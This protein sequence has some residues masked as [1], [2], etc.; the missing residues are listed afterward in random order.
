MTS[1]ISATREDHDA[2]FRLI[3]ASWTSQVTSTLAK[4]SIA[5]QFD[6]GPR[7]AREIADD[8]SSDPDMTY[9]VLRAAAALGFLVYDADTSR[10]SGTTM[11]DVLRGES[12]LSLKHYALTAGSDVHWLP[13]RR[14]AETV[15]RGRNHADDELGCSP[16]EYFGRNLPEARIFSVAM[17]ELSTP[18]ISEATPL[19]EVGDAQ[20]AV[21]V[22]GA[23]GAF[24]A[25]LLEAHESLRGV[26][27]DLPQV[28]AGVE[29][30]SRRRGLSNRMTGIPG[31]FFNEVPPADLYLLKFIL[32]DWDDESCKRILSNIRLAMRPGAK[33]FIV[34]MMADDESLEAAL[35]DMGMLTGYTG[36]ERERRHLESLVVAT[37]LRTTRAWPLHRPYLML[38][39]VSA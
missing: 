14:M 7:S 29:S 35:M 2:V 36:K 26:V 38:E 20:L 9:R 18:V 22:G 24:V 10:F 6:A 30:E 1:S 15:M 34:E 32:H 31:D 23:D 37:R 11:L 39:V 13:C 8:L 19:I 3:M 27:L 5:E 4:L 25:S 12:A 16:F 28:M 17:T 33:L 21:D